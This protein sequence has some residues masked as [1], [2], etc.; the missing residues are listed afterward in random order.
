MEDNTGNIRLGHESAVSGGA[1][2]S[3]SVLAPSLNGWATRWSG[4]QL[5]VVPTVACAVLAAGAVRGVPSSAGRPESGTLVMSRPVGYVQY[6][7]LA[8]AAY[9]DQYWQSPNRVWPDYGKDDCTNF[10]SQAMHAGGMAFVGYGLVNQPY[11]YWWA[12][13]NAQGGAANLDWKVTDDLWWYLRNYAT[14]IATYVGSWPASAGSPVVHPYTPNAVT[15]GDPIFYDWTSDGSR[16]HASMEVGQGDTVD[17]YRGS[18]IDQ[19]Q[20][21]YHTFWSGWSFNQFRHTTTFT[22]FSIVR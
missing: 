19:H 1:I 9:E 8:A 18:F 4:L 16:D 12:A 20:P 13:T 6:D 14:G 22:F 21:R 15:T 17:G 3:L 2:G 11:R 5:L 10:L 7:G